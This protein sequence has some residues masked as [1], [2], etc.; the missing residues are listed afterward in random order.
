M[1]LCANDEGINYYLLCYLQVLILILLARIRNNLL[2]FPTFLMQCGNTI[3][4]A[5]SELATGNTTYTSD[6]GKSYEFNTDT[7]AF[8]LKKTSRIKAFVF[9][10]ISVP[11]KLIRMA[12]LYQLNI[13]THNKSYQNPF[14]LT[15]G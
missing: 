12:R 13:Y 8:G 10:F 6:T 2:N 1:W 7:K 3:L 11:A 15:D 14:A 9:K 4:R 5:I